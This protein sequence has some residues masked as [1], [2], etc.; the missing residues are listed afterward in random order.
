[1]T[2]RS[3]AAKGIVLD[4]HRDYDYTD[5]NAVLGFA[6]TFLTRDDVRVA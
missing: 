5:W 1:M 2:R 3:F 4:S 6:K